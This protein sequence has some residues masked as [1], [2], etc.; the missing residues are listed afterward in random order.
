M[1][2]ASPSEVTKHYR[3]LTKR[4]AFWR[5]MVL[6][7]TIA[8]LSASTF[9]FWRPSFYF[10]LFAALTYLTFS[11]IAA[12]FYTPRENVPDLPTTL[13]TESPDGHIDKP[14]S[15]SEEDDTKQ[16][17]DDIK[18]PERLQQAPYTGDDTNPKRGLLG[19]FF[20]SRRFE[21]HREIALALVIAALPFTIVINLPHDL[22]IVLSFI[23]MECA[24]LLA[25]SLS[26]N[27]I[28]AM[29]IPEFPETMLDKT[30]V[31][32]RTT[33]AYS[34]GYYLIGEV[35]GMKIG[36][37]RLQRFLHTMIAGPTGE[38]KSSTLIVPQ[39]LFDADSPGSAVVP[40]AKS[41]ELYGMVAGRWI[42]AGKKAFLFD[43]WHPDTIAINPLLGADDMDLLTICDVMMR[44]REE[45]IGKEDAF[46]K[47]RTRYL[48][49]AMLKLVQSFKPQYCNLAT[50]YK[51]SASVPT[52][53]KFIDT[54]DEDTALLFDDF[55][56][57][58]PETRV[59]ALTSI[60]EKLDVF[61]Q[62]NVRK[63]FSKSEFDLQTL[64]AAKEP[65][66]LVLGCP[67]S[68]REAGTKIASLIVNLIINR[69]FDERRLMKVALQKGEPAFIPNDLY[70]Y[71]DELRN[72]KVT[73]LPELV[74]IARETRTQVCA[75]VTDLGFLKYYRDDF[76]SLMT[77][78]R[79]R[80]FMRGLDL[81]SAKIISDSLGKERVAAYRLFKGVMVSQENVNL[82]DPDKIMQMPE[83]KII[84]FNPKTRP[85]VADKVSI[86]KTRWLKKMQVKP[87][88]DLRALYKSW[89]KVDGKLVD[90]TLPEIKKG[91][92]DMKQI[93]GDH[94]V[95]INKNITL[96]KIHK[97]NIGGGV[98]KRPTVPRV[99]EVQDDGYQGTFEEDAALAEDGGAF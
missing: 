30:L 54:C 25:L 33:L 82:S 66:L 17:P 23:I 1:G 50:V 70:L 22:L 40:D 57:L 84:V 29:E 80:L 9:Y 79:V 71:L 3:L 20:I 77:N 93:K 62:E 27:Y 12:V 37:P 83:D 10:A 5:Q 53:Q 68:Q 48:L 2:W 14:V 99:T 6:S 61:M 87:P 56:E 65:C 26:L 7:T 34:R 24:T 13:E 86:Y 11:T 8:L 41:P 90:P 78:F 88:K 43:P 16:T 38:G 72:L 89:G 91:E 19:R 97:E 55:S 63:A 21:L 49:Y 35:N 85:F 28:D 47:S 81:D 92:Y 69:A 45:A 52:L 4:D 46:F 64:F 42:K 98:L 95:S 96:E 15:V 76:S 18:E 67:T 73:G 36:L 60:R 75:S 58:N 44:E 94:K 32:I 39:L 51:I 31:S 59:N 74:A